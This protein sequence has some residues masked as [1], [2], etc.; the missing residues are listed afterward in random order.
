MYKIRIRCFSKNTGEVFYEYDTNLFF[1]LDKILTE[2]DL[3]RSVFFNRLRTDLKEDCTFEFTVLH[4]KEELPLFNDLEEHFD[5]NEP[6]V[7]F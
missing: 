3:A 1:K 2:L 6:P 4:I 7:V 5:F